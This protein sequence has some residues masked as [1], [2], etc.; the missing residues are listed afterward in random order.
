[1]GTKS[2]EKEEGKRKRKKTARR[3]EKLTG[4]REKVGRETDREGGGGRGWADLAAVTSR[5]LKAKITLSC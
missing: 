5:G 1:M 2:G 4:K 3:I